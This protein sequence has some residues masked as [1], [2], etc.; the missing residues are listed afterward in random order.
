MASPAAPSPP[1]AVGAPTFVNN[2]LG[3]ADPPV[4]TVGQPVT[5]SWN[6]LWP[7]FN[8]VQFVDLWLCGAADF[9]ASCTPIKT[10]V[11]NQQGSLTWTVPTNVGKD[12]G[13]WSVVVAENGA[14]SSDFGRLGVPQFAVRVASGSAGNPVGTPPTTVSITPS[15][16]PASGAPPSAT[17]PPSVTGTAVR[18]T[19]GATERQDPSKTAS[20]TGAA[21]TAL[22]PSAGTNSDS[23]IDDQSS[24]SSSGFPWWAGLLIGL[25]VVAVV[26]A[27]FIGGRRRNRGRQLRAGGE[28]AMRNVASPPPPMAAAGAASPRS[29]SAPIERSQIMAPAPAVLADDDSTSSF[30]IT[31]TVPGTETRNLVVLV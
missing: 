4:L 22:A 16:V 28:E 18:A 30:P 20:P 23:G 15:Q 10:A 9:P 1:S 24:N 17:R 25:A 29:V 7:S 6:Q 26:A 13:S 14:A 8:V 12:G 19:P 21:A 2:P 27:M 5:L 3:Q 31:G 11:P